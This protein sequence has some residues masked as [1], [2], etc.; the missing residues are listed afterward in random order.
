MA[1]ALIC[2]AATSA[3]AQT[4]LAELHKLLQEKAAFEETDFAALQRGETVVRPAP[5]QDKGEVAVSG[6]VTL[7]ASADEF[8]RSYRESLTRKSNGA[9]MEVGTFGAVPAPADLESLTLEADD[10][11]DL[12]AC[13]V[14][15]CEIKL[16]A[17][18]I[19]R[20]GREVNWQA[21]DYAHQATQ[22]FKTMLLEYVKDYRSRGDAALI[23]YH[24]KQHE[25]RLANEHQA[26]TRAS[27]YLSDVFGKSAA[28]EMQPLEELLVWS[29][30]KF[31]LKPVIAINHVTIYKR[32]RELGPQILAVSKQIYANHYFNSSLG[33]TGFVTVAGPTSYLV[34]ENRSRA[35]GLEGPFGKLKRGIV[36]KKALEGLKGIL[37][38]SKLTMEAPMMAR[39]STVASA[40]ASDSW[41]RRL[42]GGIRPLL[43]FLIISALIALLALRN[44]EGKA[45]RAAVKQLK[46]EQ[47]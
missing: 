18:M 22:L 32:D 19:Q 43:W 11:E 2:A 36:Q 39:E 9:V 35:D 31:G 25:I 46:P 29:K 37:E 42:F 6:L 20:F 47:R 14:G 34:Y 1:Y 12:K 38:H 24:D 30:I 16:S 17:A 26:L 4:S 3:V 40:N 21:T 5:T 45:N 8:L 44:Y 23:E 41:S 28:S 13:V 33:L 10:I 15:A 7:R 27:G